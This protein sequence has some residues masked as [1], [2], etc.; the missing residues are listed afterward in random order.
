MARCY[1]LYEAWIIRY[2]FFV[3]KQ[4]TR[5]TFQLMV[6][7]PTIIHQLQEQEAITLL[8]L[9]FG[10][11][12]CGCAIKY[13]EARK[14]DPNTNTPTTPTQPVGAGKSDVSHNS[15]YSIFI[16]FINSVINYWYGT[17]NSEP[18]EIVVDLRSEELHPPV[19]TETDSEQPKPS[20]RLETLKDVSDLGLGP[21]IGAGSRIDVSIPHQGKIVFKEKIETRQ[22]ESSVRRPRPVPKRKRPQGAE[23]KKS[24][25][26]LTSEFIAMCNELETMGRQNEIQHPK[27]R[28]LENQLKECVKKPSLK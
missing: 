5:N 15:F 20:E 22:S 10:I 23:P 24:Q 16:T 6:R 8:V 12:A 27:L 13:W 7:H 9:A 3:N 18:S 17:N 28:K 21:K 11:I 26:E 25:E 2:N 4:I 14:S 1:K 19:S